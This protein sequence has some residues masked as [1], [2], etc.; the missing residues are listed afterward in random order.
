VAGVLATTAM[1]FGAASAQDA[2][3]TTAG[4]D[5]ER[6]VMTVG[7]PQGLD[8][9]NVTV[10]VTVAAYEVWNL[11]FATLTDKAADD[12]STIPGLAESWEG[13]DDG[14][15]YTYHLRDGLT[16]SDDE[17]LTADDVV[18]TID[19]ANEEGWFNHTATTQNLTA[20]AIDDQT[21]EITSAVPDPK[22]PTMDIYIVPKHVYED[23]S[24][25]ELSSYEALDG[26]GSGPFHLTD[27]TRGQSWT[28]DANPNWWGGDTYVDEIVFRPFSNPDAM[29]TALQRGEI[30]AAH[31]IPAGAVPV[32]ADESDIE[33]VEGQ[34]GGFDELALNAGGGPVPGGNPA[35]EDL[36]F[37]QAI[38]YAIDKEAIVDRVYDG[39]AE[40]ATTMSPSPD[41]QWIPD[42]PVEDQYTFDPDRANELLDDA[43]YEDT[44]GD[45]VREDPD[46]GEAIN[47]RYAVRSES[48]IAQPI[49][50]LVTGWLSDIGIDTTTEQFNDT[51]LTPFIG[52]GEWD[53][54]V[55][56]WTPFVD[57]DPQLS[58]FKCDQTVQDADDP[59]NY[60]NDANWCSDEYDDL[61]VEQNQ[62]LDHDRRVELVHEM[63]TLFYEDAA[64]VVLDYAPDLQ[65]YRT[66]RFQGWVRQPA[67]TGPVIFSNT[68]PSYA[69][70]EPVT[71]A[72][73]GGDDD[74]GGSSTGLIIGI[75]VIGLLIVGG[76]AFA[77]GR[78]GSAD[79]RE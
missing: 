8:S 68:S 18:Y 28:M 43:G 32:L 67:E 14:L 72:E 79:D 69:L 51:Q 53:M 54:F 77:L 30:D 57:P 22:L 58:Y 47:L 16:W 23:I 27:Y 65:A 12:F 1:G 17:P 34:Q 40:P 56:G 70:L 37:R 9:A 3:T 25:D 45:G 2:T 29:V 46:T 15:T 26:V 36:A 11:Q 62:E 60:Y 24:A 49:A 10:G 31:N 55:W 7:I 35:L 44:D 20:E 13:S 48:E 63:L 41:P 6:V 66:D 59:T 75:A 74:D 5:D 21:V 73:G 61:Y 38:N 71:A 64:Y 19:R 4:G 39:L 50:E 78:R 33:V 76:G 42:I 52:R